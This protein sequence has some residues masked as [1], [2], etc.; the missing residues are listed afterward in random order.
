MSSTALT[1]AAPHHRTC[2]IEPDEYWWGPTVAH[3]HLMPFTASTS[4]AADLDREAHGNQAQPLLLSSHGRWLW[5]EA[6][7]TVQIEAGTISV[8]SLAPVHQGQAGGGL[9]GA[10]REVATRF[11]PADG[12]I[13]AE[14]LFTQPQYNTWIELTYHQSQEAILAYAH[15]LIDEGYPP[16]VLMIDD[17]WQAG[18]GDWRFAPER[19]SDP[20]AMVDELHQ[21]GFAVML[22]VAPYLSADGP[23]Y[24]HLREQGGLLRNQHGHPVYSE[25]WNGVSAVLDLSRE[26]D[27]SW[28]QGELDRLQRVYGVDG[29]KF[30]AGDPRAYRSNLLGG[31]EPAFAEPSSPSDQCERYAAIG[32]RYPLNEYRACYRLAGR[33]L[34]QRLRDKGHNWQDLQKLIPEAI[35]QGLLGYA[36]ICPDMIGGG[37]WTSFRHNAPIDQ[38][39]FVRSAQASA[40]FPMMQFSAAPWRVLDAKHAAL[41]H[42]AAQL[43]Q[44][45]GTEILKMAK[46]AG[47]TGEPILRPL[48]YAHPGRGW[49]QI[50]DQFLLGES[51]LVA[52]VLTPG[53]RERSVTLPPGRWRADDGAEYAGDSTV[54]VAAPLERL[55][56]FRRMDA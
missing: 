2:R 12:T 36:F 3:G 33:P 16:G 10:L 26:L 56:W 51:I 39:L 54:T 42:A 34:A 50:S 1:S 40:L 17:T 7:I 31:A 49:D 44:E 27:R 4:F 35:C 45:L 13:P 30:D 24:R 48:A 11:F 55:P 29:F 6:A 18:Y 47:A 37:E 32:L 53:Q 23:A 41:C 22:W 21:L 28:L 5:G 46:H 38:E 8:S 43:H 15:R 20:A 25:W 52:P 14:L 19:F 9:Q